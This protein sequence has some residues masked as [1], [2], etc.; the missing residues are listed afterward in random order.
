MSSGFCERC[1]LVFDARGP[2]ALL[3]AALA[4]M[5][6]FLS[7]CGGGGGDDESTANDSTPAQQL[8]TNRPP[9][10]FG[11]P[12]HAVTPSSA[13]AFT[14]LAT[15]ADGDPLTFEISGKPAWAR[16]DADTGRLS[17]TPTQGDVGAGGPIAISV[18][19]GVARAALAAFTINVVGTATGSVS[20][21]WLPPTENEDGT[22]LTDL[23]GYKL[24]W[25]T[26][27]G[28]YPNSVTLPNPGVTRYVVEHL[29]PATWHFVLTATTSR[30][31]ES[32]Y[33]NDTS[34][35]LL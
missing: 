5:A 32:D 15:D 10:I 12:P 2:R 23:S 4:A 7:S 6:A 16:F 30:G 9:S 11:T 27:E 3:P 29:T 31:S 1:R 19:D 34:S 17:G 35:E 21:V 33:S 24:Y 14:P 22:P 28:D 20:L 18:T 25:G 8:P 13:Y 26:T